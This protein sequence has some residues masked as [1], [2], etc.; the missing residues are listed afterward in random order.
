[1]RP[2]K[3]VVLGGDSVVSGGVLRAVAG[4]AVP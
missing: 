4:F 1:M 3:I 2:G